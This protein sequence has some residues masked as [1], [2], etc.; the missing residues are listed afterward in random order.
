LRALRD[1]GAAS[2]PLVAVLMDSKPVAD[3]ALDGLQTVVAAF[4]GGQAC[5]Q[6]IAE[7]LLGVTEP[8]G[9]LPISFPVSAEVLPVFYSRRPSGASLSSYCDV[10]PNAAV[11]WPFGHGLAYTSFNLS[12]L[13]LT[14]SVA[15]DGAAV[16][17][18]TVT[19]VGARAGWA[20][21]QLYLRRLA[22][23]VTTPALSLKGFARLFLL[24]GA[25]AVATFAVDAAAELGVVG[26]DLVTRVEPGQVAALVGF[27]SADLPLK[28]VFSVGA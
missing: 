17:N 6:A 12:D 9:R 14:P 28:G 2:P 10:S 11:R 24:P 20:V 26:R 7:V 27:S 8:S 23:S 13:S 3:A 21:P 16:V 4:Q 25:S 1:A 19:N 18:A 22:A 15:A 5:G